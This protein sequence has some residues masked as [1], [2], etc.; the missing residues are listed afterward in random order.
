M[1]TGSAADLLGLLSECDALSG[2]FCI[3]FLDGRDVVVDDRLVDKR[4]KGF[5]RLQLGTIGR[6]INEANAI[7]NFE[8]GLPMPY[9]RNRLGSD[10]SAA[11]S[12]TSKMMRLKPAPASRAKVSSKASKNSFATPLETYQKVSPAAGGTNAVT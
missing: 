12:S 2:D 6:Q 7:G 8:I 9:L 1:E 5:G 4:P 10:C 11:L 3:E